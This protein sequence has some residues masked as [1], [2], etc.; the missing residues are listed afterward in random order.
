CRRRGGGGPGWF[1]R[2]WSVRSW[3]ISLFRQPC[4]DALQAG[5]QPIEARGQI[6]SEALYFLGVAGFGFAKLFMKHGHLFPDLVA[7]VALEAA[8][9]AGRLPLAAPVAAGLGPALDL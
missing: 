8:A 4:A 3:Q 5:P 6:L 1:R 2:V 7:A 9:L